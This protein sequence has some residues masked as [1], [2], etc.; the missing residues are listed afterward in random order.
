MALSCQPET[1]SSFTSK[2]SLEVFLYKNFEIDFSWITTFPQCVHGVYDEEM[3]K[4][5]GKY[6]RNY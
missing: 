6:S 2:C 1:H 5:Q 4:I 3:E